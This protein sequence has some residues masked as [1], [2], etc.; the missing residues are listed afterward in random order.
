FGEFFDYQSDKY[1][2]SFGEQT[3]QLKAFSIHL[4]NSGYLGYDVGIAKHI[5]EIDDGKMELCITE[6][7]PKWQFAFMASLLFFS[8][9]KWSKRLKIHQ[10]ESA[11]IQ[12]IESGKTKM[13]LGMD[14]E[15]MKC[16]NQ[17][18]V[19]LIPKGLEVI[20]P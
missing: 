19:E 6:Q 14:G 16:P 2:I 12:L 10:V 13:L 7:F 3:E 17:L 15:F 5:A 4:S 9:L 8:K 1:E 11:Q 20:V 18:S